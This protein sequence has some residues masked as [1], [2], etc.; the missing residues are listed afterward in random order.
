MRAAI[1]AEPGSAAAT[2][3]RGEQLAI[4]PLALLRALLGLHALGQ[5]LDHAEARP[6]A[7]EIEIEGSDLHRDDVAIFLAVAPDPAAIVRRVF[8]GLAQ[9][10]D[11]LLGA[12]LLG[13]EREELLL[14]ITIKAHRSVVDREEGERLRIDYPHRIRIGVEQ[15][16][17]APFAF[18]ERLLVARTLRDVLADAM[19]AAKFSLL[20][21]QRLA[22]NREIAQLARLVVV[23]EDEVGERL[24]ARELGAVLLPD[25]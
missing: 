5:I 10:V 12:D 15:G 14:R 4:A 13:G 22:A 25:L 17:V 3:L 16:A 20:V 19:V 7:G 1:L 24:V 18:L 8:E 23:Q 21:E 11:V 6:A 2:R 9:I